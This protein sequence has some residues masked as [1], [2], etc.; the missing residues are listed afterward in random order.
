MSYHIIKQG[1]VIKS[2]S[3]LVQYMEQNKVYVNFWG[4]HENRENT[5]EILPFIASYAREE[6]PPD[7]IT[8]GNDN[9]RP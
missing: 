4:E 6:R 5:L 9:S 8:E 7:E 3:K 1:K 2:V